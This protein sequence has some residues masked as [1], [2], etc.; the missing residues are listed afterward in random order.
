VGCVL[1]RRTR[2]SYILIGLLLVVCAA[3]VGVVLVVGAEVVEV[4]CVV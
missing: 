2:R 1:E 4:L 3:G